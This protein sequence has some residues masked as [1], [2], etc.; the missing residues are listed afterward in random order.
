VVE[1]ATRHCSMRV[2]LECAVFLPVCRDSSKSPACSQ[3]HIGRTL[4]VRTALP[5]M[6]EATSSQQ[7]RENVGSPL[8]EPRKPCTLTKHGDRDLFRVS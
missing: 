5:E 7:T 2:E 8:C 3:G 4:P 1:I 6:E